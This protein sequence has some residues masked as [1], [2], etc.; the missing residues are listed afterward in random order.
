MIHFSI[1][2]DALGNFF[3]VDSDNSRIQIFDDDGEF[4]SK[5]GSADS[6]IDEYLGSAVQVL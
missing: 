2:I 1:A 4:Q 6:G 3:V 5:F